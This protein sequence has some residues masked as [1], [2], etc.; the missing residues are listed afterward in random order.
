MQQNKKLEYKHFVLYKATFM[1]V[2]F[3]DKQKL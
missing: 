3:E 2:C 1:N